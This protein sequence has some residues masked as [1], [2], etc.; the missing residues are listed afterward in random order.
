MSNDFSVVQSDCRILSFH[1]MM[2]FNTLTLSNLL[3]LFQQIFFFFV[4]RKTVIESLDTEDLVSL[5]AISNHVFLVFLNLLYHVYQ[6]ILRCAK[7]RRKGLLKP[8]LLIQVLLI[9]HYPH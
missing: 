5:L 2:I 1:T 6:Y 8:H 7:K 9:H 4:C 3:A